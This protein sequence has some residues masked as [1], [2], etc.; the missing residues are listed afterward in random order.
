MAKLKFLRWIG[1]FSN[2]PIALQIPHPQSFK[3]S[4]T[5]IARCS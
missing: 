2:F 1:A 3:A 5:D 4:K